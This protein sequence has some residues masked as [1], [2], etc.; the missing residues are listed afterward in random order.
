MVRIPYIPSNAF[1]WICMCFLAAQPIVICAQ[2]E[3]L[4]TNASALA[5]VDESGLH[6][7]AAVADFDGDGWE[8]IYVATKQ[9]INRLFR[10]TGGM[11]FEEVAEAAGVNDAGNSNAALWADF[12]NDGW[13]DLVTGN[14]L[15]ANRLYINNG[16][17]TF[18]DATDIYNFGNEGPCRSLHAADYDGDGW[19]DVYV[20]NMNSHNAMYRNMGGQ[21]FQNV[22]FPTGTVD[23]GIGMGC[24]FFDSDNDGDQDLYVTHDGNQ[25][26][27]FF[28]NN[29]DGTFA[30]NAAEVGLDYQGNCM[31]VDVA[32]INHDGWLDVYITD[33]YPS[34][35]FLNDGDGT[36]TA[37]GETA[38]V[39]DSGMSW[40]CVWFDYNL[41]SEW[42][43]YV[44]NDYAFA[45]TANRLYRG[46]GDMTYDLVSE[47]D[48][49]LEHTYSD[50][51]L[52]QG[53][54]DRD[55]DLDLAIAT[56]G[57]SVQPGFQILE[58]QNETGHFIQF[59]LE[60]TISNRS[61]I[62]ARVEIH[63]NG[64][65]R[66]DEINCGQGYSGASS[67]VVHFGLGESTAIDSM[68]VIWP[69]GVVSAHGAFNADSTYQ[70]LEPGSQPWFQ[71]GCTEPHAC[72]YNIAA[73]T[74]DGSCFYPDAG[75]DCNGMPLDD[76]P[77]L[78]THSIARLWNEALLIGVRN[79]LARPTV[80]ARNLWH[81]SA[82]AYD[83]WAAW[84][85]PSSVG[86]QTW[87][88]G[89]TIGQFICPWIPGEA[90]ENESERKS[91][92]ERSI[93]YGSYRLMLHRFEN[94]PRLQR[95]LTHLHSQ[96]EQLGY[97][98]AFY[99]TDYT[100]GNLE[101]DAGALGNYLAEQYIAFGLQDGAFEEINYQN[102]YYN[103]VNW[104]LV[105]DEPGNPNMFFPNRW[106]PLQL[107]E[108]IDQS[109]NEGTNVSPDFLS[110]EWGNV[111]P[112]AMDAGDTAVYSRLGSEYTVYH[113][114]PSPPIIDP[115][116]DSDLENDYKWGHS[117]VSLWSS[118]LDP[119]DSVV[120]DISP[121]ASGLSGFLPTNIE[122][123]R[124]YYQSESGVIQAPNA[125]P[126]HPINPHTGEPYASQE[127]FRGDFT[128]VLAEFWADGPDSET[129]PGHWF[130]LLNYVN[131]QEA[132]VRSWRGNGEEL[133]LLDWD[134]LGYF[135]MGGAMHD[136]AISAWS[137]KG[138][139]DYVRPVSA[140]RW[141]ADRGQ[142]SDP[143]QPNFDGA[144]LPLIPGKIEL[145]TSDDSE[146]LRGSD[147]EHLHELKVMAWRGPDYI[148]VPALNKAGVG[149][150]RAREWWPYQRP[151]FVTPPFAGY[152]SGHS[153][154]SRA[155]AE[156][157][158]LLT[159]DDYFPGGMG[160]FPV[161][162]NEFLVFE[163]G[164]SE[165]FELQWATY[166]DAADQSALSRIW[167][168]IHPPQDDFPGRAIGQV[169]GIDAFLLAESYAFPLL[170]D[171][172][173]CAGDFNAD[174]VRNLYDLLLLLVH[175][176]ESTSGGGNVAPA[177][178]DLDS[179]GMIS[180]SDLL[181]L[182]T[183][184][185]VPC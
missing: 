66:V 63:F 6:H 121:G 162:A 122:E 129:P 112:F 163:D 175:F 30:E 108:F 32:D 70:V 172:T 169:V 13:P 68:N 59:K 4:F 182:L 99:S 131:D 84:A 23:T 107:L 45:P 21:T 5:N 18:E 115:A 120:W 103:P 134:V 7:A 135:A 9:G 85:I 102:T 51:G 20:V 60:G 110:A 170:V 87:L 56:T 114:A 161:E 98:T 29:G 43:L 152:V 137:N 156:V 22:T 106:Q 89:D 76:W 17:G 165:D 132:L 136:A 159:G 2:S 33:L 119:Q 37:I 73:Q 144:G 38:G 177:T 61:A 133:S 34:E 75:L 14:Y 113:A 92:R 62:G 174:Q 185:G 105:M 88:L 145:I 57:S 184:W 69:S 27:K 55:G 155:A 10:N 67:L 94:A 1:T 48:P 146:E 36:Y 74:N 47:G 183:V 53:D 168:G 82:L 149:W 16:N 24:V 154:F 79:D 130:T 116:Q 80:H 178:L 109:G 164:P 35:L 97:D 11:H 42:D 166:R 111:Q 25:V 58:N 15:N 40:G 101:H 90:I 148:A 19:I 28:E 176:G 31:G 95:I 141:M 158:C 41:D 171:P 151:T 44:V 39:N 128:R 123:A 64:Q 139:Y 72:N 150:I 140:I 143:E 153:T 65:T 96:M 142:S 54:F 46:N 160:S 3:A 49:V 118:H 100:T 173:N 117:L 125:T 78:T 104:N 91:A 167:G 157:L 93:S 180:T 127:V 138:W 26:N 8:D 52:A 124:E 12:N 181:G 50:Y 179:D 147:N 71:L 81:Q 86:P 83:A 77:T 126:G